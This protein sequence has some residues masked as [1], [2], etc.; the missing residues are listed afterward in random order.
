MKKFYHKLY[1]ITFSFLLLNSSFFAISLF[2]SPGIFSSSGNSDFIISSSSPTVEINLEPNSLVFEGDIINC[3]ITGSPTVKYWTINGQKIHTTFYE[4]NPVLFDP[5]ATPLDDTHVNLTVYVENSDGTDSDTVRV[6]L[7][8]IYFGDIHFHSIQSDGRSTINTLYKKAREDNYL[9]F[10]CLSDH[11]E[12]IDEVIPKSP[13]PV[14]NWVQF[15]FFKYLKV[16][17]WN[18]IKNKAKEFYKPGR[19]TTFLGFE[20]SAS[21]EFPGGTP[22]SPY[23]REDVSHINFYYKDVYPDAK[24]YSADEKYTFDDIFKAMSDEWDKGHL[25]LGFP[26]H[27]LVD[28]GM[29]INTVNFTFLADGVSNKQARDKILRGVETYSCWGTA[30]GKYSGLPIV[31][32]YLKKNLYDQKDAW[33]ENSL[34]KC[35]EGPPKGGSFALM[36]SSD[37]HFQSRPGSARP[38]KPHNILSFHPDNP[39]GLVA[40]Y[41]VHNTREDIWNAMY[42][43]DMYATQLLKNRINVRYDGQMAT[44]RWINC[45]SPLEIQITAHSTFKGKDSS[46]RN[47]KPHGYS[48]NELDYP[49]SDVWIIKKD[50]EKGRP[51]CKVINHTNPNKN[52]A[53]INFKDFDVEPNDFYFIAIKQK[54]ENLKRPLA[55]I[56]PSAPGDEYMSFI[57]PVFID[58]VQ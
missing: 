58:N 32:P 31:W 51:W 35:S 4:D 16:S 42:N 46:G 19:F 48:E 29:E 28:N 8:R 13:Y 54:G 5:E 44:G 41:S 49:I 36:A 38:S 11:A 57:G 18:I 25:N 24:E 22:D 45:S 39:S 47:M 52:L 55:K 27:P 37:I 43:C 56:N 7:K 53:V 15:L 3:T 10:A 20:W 33:V 23:G 14:L 21:S 2:N 9:D 40:V 17:E 26:H 30:I 1:V 12:I 50:I 34:W 6:I